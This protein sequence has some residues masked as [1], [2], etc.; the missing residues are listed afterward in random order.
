MWGCRP[1]SLFLGC[2]WLRR[3]SSGH[4]TGC[5]FGCRLGDG[6]QS[7]AGFWFA[8]RSLVGPESTPAPCRAVCCLCVCVSAGCSLCVLFVCCGARARVCCVC[9]A[10]R[11]RVCAVY[12]CVCV[13]CVCVRGL[14]VCVFWCP[15]AR[16]RPA[17]FALVSL[18]LLRA[19]AVPVLTLNLG[20]RMNLG[21]VDGWQMDGVTPG[22]GVWL[23]CWQFPLSF[24]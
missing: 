11:A 16:G 10:A 9:A 23:L 1:F 3:W 7:P 13:L 17:C 15:C 2:T 12:L 18:C 24:L 6:W 21:L 8:A 4:P 19:R 20:R 22:C 14:C 5:E